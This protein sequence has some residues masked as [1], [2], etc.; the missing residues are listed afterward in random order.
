MT[1]GAQQRGIVGET[2][3]IAAQLQ[4]LAEPDTAVIA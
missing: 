1:G 2:P 4:A 3:N